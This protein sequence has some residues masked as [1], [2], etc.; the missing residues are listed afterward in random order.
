MAQPWDN[1]P[2]C[3]LNRT[4][5]H[6]SANNQFSDYLG[7]YKE[8]GG[9][10]NRGGGA[11]AHPPRGTSA[12]PVRRPADSTSTSTSTASRQPPALRWPIWDTPLLSIGWAQQ[13]RNYPNTAR[14]D[15]GSPNTEAGMG[16]QGHTMRRWGDDA[17]RAWPR[18]PRG[19]ARGPRPRWRSGCIHSWHS[20]WGGG[21]HVVSTPATPFWPSM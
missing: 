3:G 12:P 6:R 15:E 7:Q 2:C 1:G 11:E 14:A 4:P 17:P 18:L 13:A 9:A 20:A 10:S 16:W 8:H 21:A 19:A 5:L